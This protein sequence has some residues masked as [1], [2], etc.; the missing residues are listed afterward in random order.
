MALLS[1]KYALV[2]GAAGGLGLAIAQR[3]SKDGCAGLCIDLAAEAPGLPDGWHYRRCDVSS[4]PDFMDTAEWLGEAF[5]RLDIAVAN[6]GIVPP[7]RRT[8]DL[9]LDEWD[10]V[11]AVN[12][13]GIATTIKHCIPLMRDAGGSIIAM[14]SLNSRQ[15]HPQQAAYTASKHAVLGLVRATALDLGRLGIRVNAL[16]PGPIATDALVARVRSRAEADGMPGDNAL[17]DYAASTAL[18][19]LATADDVAGAALY[20]ASEQSAGVTGQ[21]LPVDSG[22]A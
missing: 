12:V 20:L 11:F 6:A 17:A 1:D 5:G 7:W 8:E 4:E 15:G 22:I 9:D 18:G 3:L 2:T 10:R 21:L 19:R 14:G 13:R 16:A